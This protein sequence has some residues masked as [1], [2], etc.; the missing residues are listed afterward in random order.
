MGPTIHRGVGALV[1]VS[2]LKPTL[3]G[4][5]GLEVGHRGGQRCAGGAE[6]RLAVRW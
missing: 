4:N 6:N 1:R 5:L 3:A 2:D